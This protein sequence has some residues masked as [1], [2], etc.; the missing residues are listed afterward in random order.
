M[1][2]IRDNFVRALLSTVERL[3]ADP[4]SSVDQE[5]IRSALLQ[6][7][8]STPDN[9]ACSEHIEYGTFTEKSLGA[10]HRMGLKVVGKDVGL[11][12]IAWEL[13]CDEVVDLVMSRRPE[14]SREEI[15]AA[16]RASTLLLSGFEVQIKARS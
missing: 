2:Q 16:L 6:Q 4:T 9:I 5:A 11:S 1:I 12:D 15:E 8:S 14:L 13:E 3:T 10:K 7:A